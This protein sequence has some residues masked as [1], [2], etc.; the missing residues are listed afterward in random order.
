VTCALAAALSLTNCTTTRPQ[1]LDIA[2]T[3]S[4]Q[5]SGLLDALLPAYREDSGVVV[6]VHAAGSG[7]ALQMMAEGLVQLVISHAPDAE[8]R[9]LGEHPDWIRLDL[10]Y[11][12]FVIVGP[13]SDAAG[14]RAAS[15]AAEAFRRIAQSS[16][17]FVSRGD[18]SGT[19]ERENALWDAAGMRPPAE[20]LI[21][22]GRGMAL[23][24]RHANELSGYTLSDEATFRQ[25]E[26]ELELHLLF[27]GD[28]RLL[29]TYA[30]LHPRSD[31]AAG[32]LASWLVGD[33]GRARIGGFAIGGKP[34]FTVPA[35]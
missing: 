7:R 23:A 10:A 30:V 27:Q 8:T 25:F 34:M 28:A 6:R 26:H 11:N 21:V 17:P 33:E 20:R 5:N 16:L 2:T 31:A 12:Q 9:A 32:R 24:L 18:L 4:V 22:S 29:N 1:P 19:H 14:V 35:H 13:P 15:D 3:S